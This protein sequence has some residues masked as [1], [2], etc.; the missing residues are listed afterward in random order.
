MGLFQFCATDPMESARNSSRKLR[1]LR[2]RPVPSFGCCYRS[3]WTD[4]HLS[5]RSS[6]LRL[7]SS[8]SS[9]E[10]SP[11][12]V[13]VN[14]IQHTQQMIYQHPVDSSESPSCT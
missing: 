7:A 1:A 13:E 10:R 11:V 3:P 9:R 2:H 8:L 14:S 5:I 6:T 4:S 12:G